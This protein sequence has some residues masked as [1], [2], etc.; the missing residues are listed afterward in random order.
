MYNIYGKHCFLIR[1][2]KATNLVLNCHMNSKDVMIQTYSYSI[3]SNAQKVHCIMAK[4][5]VLC[6]S[7]AVETCFHET[8]GVV[9][10][11]VQTAR[12]TSHLKLREVGNRYYFQIH[13]TYTG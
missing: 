12:W 13:S 11:Q 1:G 2:F 8:K 6:L 3:K 4:T 5:T 7:L 10:P 9:V